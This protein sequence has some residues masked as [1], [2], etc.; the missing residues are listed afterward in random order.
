[1]SKSSVKPSKPTT[2][3]SVYQGNCPK[4]STRGVGN[5]SYEL[6]TDEAGNGHVRISANASSGAF[7]NEW[8]SLAGIK[9]NL[10]SGPFSSVA[11]KDLF[12][13]RS[14][15]NHGYLAAILKAEG[16]I[17]VLPGKPIMLTLGTW[18]TIEQKFKPAKKA[19]DSPP[20][21]E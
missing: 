13:R 20:T 4:L 3:K 19:K 16:V 11:M 8:V 7:S 18:D 15:N 12:L 10:K 17:T 6:G 2:I 1:M 14:A 9:P 5:L 21:G